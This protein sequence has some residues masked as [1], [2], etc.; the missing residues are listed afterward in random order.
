MAKITAKTTLG[1][2][3]EKYPKAAQV[4]MNY[5]LHCIGCHIAVSETVEHGAQMHGLS[6]EELKKMLNEMNAA[7]K[8]A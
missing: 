7:V 1:D 6:E 5:G 2:V 3:V 8:T 4:L